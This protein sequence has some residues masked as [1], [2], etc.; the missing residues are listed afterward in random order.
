MKTKNVCLKVMEELN[1]E[2]GANVIEF[3]MQRIVPADAQM[4]ECVQCVFKNQE[5]PIVMT[6]QQDN[7]NE[8]GILYGPEIVD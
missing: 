3:N 5:E 7:G 8:E 1:I 2:I 4:S 6:R